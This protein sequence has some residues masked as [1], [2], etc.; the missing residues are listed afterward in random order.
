MTICSGPGCDEE[1]GEAMMWKLSL[2]LSIKGWM[3]KGTSGDK[4]TVIGKG[5]RLALRK[6]QM[7]KMM[8][9]KMRKGNTK[10]RQRSRKGRG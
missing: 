4:A 9:M 3:S 1:D 7:E 5:E 8:Q 2:F 6:H 10:V